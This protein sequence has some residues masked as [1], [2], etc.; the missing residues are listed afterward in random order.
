[1]RCRRLGASW[2][3]ART[4][5]IGA[6]SAGFA[7]ATFSWRRVWEGAVEAPSHLPRPRAKPCQADRAAG[8]LRADS[9]AGVEAVG[10]LLRGARARCAHDL[11]EKMA[12]VRV[13]DDVQ[14]PAAGHGH[15][16]GQSWRVGYPVESLRRYCRTLSTPRGGTPPRANPRGAAALR[17][18]P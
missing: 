17:G 9:T 13:I 15:V 14:A 6:P 3:K 11:G 10:E 1:M 16:Q 4:T 18:T 7:D 5:Y 8:A 12:L 2:E